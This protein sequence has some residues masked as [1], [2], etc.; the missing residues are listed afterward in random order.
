ML[1]KCRD[2]SACQSQRGFALIIV[3]WGLGLM[4]LL[5]L[6]FVVTV[7]THTKLTS[8]VLDHAKA[9]AMADGGINIVLLDL[10]ETSRL[11][12]EKRRFAHNGQPVLCLGKQN[13]ILS[14]SAQDEAGKID[15]NTANEAL[16]LSL[17]QGLGL[18]LDIANKYTDAIIDFRDTDN[19]KRLNGAEEKEYK[20]A[21]KP[22]GPKNFQF[23][24]IGELHQVLGLSDK[25]IT[26]LKPLVT[27]YSKRSGFDANISPQ[28]LKEA[29]TKRKEIGL[30]KLVS[31][32]KTFTISAIAKT[33]SGTLFTRRAVIELKNNT[34]KPYA[35]HSW[36]QDELRKEEEIIHKTKRQGLP[37]C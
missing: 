36:Q 20:E 12:P 27:I 34:Q 24:T 21:G 33:P 9:Q 5:V 4:A 16:L 6:S 3:I 19:L 15:L 1:L 10:L 30:Y 35:I 13:I 29:L 37:Q 22:Y 32:R 17:F 7:R 14:L 31:N 8:N 28:T 2:A 23:Q 26:Q 25:I 18:P 11:L